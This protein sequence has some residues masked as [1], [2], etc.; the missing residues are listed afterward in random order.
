MPRIGGGLI[1]R[2][3]PITV[4]VIGCAAANAHALAPPSPWDGRK[5]FRCEVQNARFE[6]EGRHP[7]RDPY[8]VHFNKTR[9]NVTGLGI[10]DFLSKEPA[11]V[12]AALPKCFYYQ[13]DR[14]RAAVVQNDATTKL[15]HW[16]GHYFFDKARGDGGVW[17]TEFTVNGQTGDP[18][19]LPGFP[20]EWRP[21]FGPGEGGFVTHNQIQSD[22]RCVE[23]AESEGNE[24]YKEGAR[25]GAS[26]PAAG[27][28]SGEGSDGADEGSGAPG[29]DGILGSLPLG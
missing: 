26:T 4:L 1:G 10:V 13:K 12:A 17:V 25:A 11:R 19:E 3:A 24:I 9:Q 7:G 22:P 6:A 5:P 14:W 28:G 23:R 16:R 21:F 15:Y 29:F 20:E 8:C 18:R 2:V 27:D